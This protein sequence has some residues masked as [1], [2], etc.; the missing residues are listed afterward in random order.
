MIE[1]GD[2]VAI[3]EN[4]YI[5]FP[6]EKWAEHFAPVTRFL[7][8]TDNER[9][10]GTIKAKDAH[11]RFVWTHRS[12][13]VKHYPKQLPPIV[14]KWADMVNAIVTPAGA[15]RYAVDTPESMDTMTSADL[16]ALARADMVEI[17]KTFLARGEKAPSAW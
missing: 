1:K 8:V 7:M 17:D 12:E 3:R 11:G 10:N 5:D 9:N 6:G 2:I 13:V 16:A 4:K 14:Y 15:F